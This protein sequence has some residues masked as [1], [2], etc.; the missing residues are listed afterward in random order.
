MKDVSKIQFI[1]KLTGFTGLKNVGQPFRVAYK[2]VACPEGTRLS[3]CYDFVGDLSAVLGTGKLV[4]GQAGKPQCYNWPKAKKFRRTE[5]EKCRRFNKILENRKWKMENKKISKF[6]NFVIS[7]FNILINQLT[8]H[9]L[10]NYQNQR[11]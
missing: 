10:T 3:S 9:Q 6:R 2:I 7:N 1:L 5:V 4:C 8:N 11:R